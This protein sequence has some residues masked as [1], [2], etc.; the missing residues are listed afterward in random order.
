MEKIK[1]IVYGTSVPLNTNVLWL[2]P[3][4]NKLIAPYIFHNGNWVSINSWLRDYVDSEDYN[5]QRNAKNYTDEQVKKLSDSLKK[6]IDS[7]LTKKQDKLVSGTNI[8]T[9]NS[10]SVLGE[11][12]INIQ[13]N[14]QSN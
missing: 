12:N 5:I 11:G 10:E 2:K 14:S 7:E 4:S 8:K 1:E 3:Y 6:Y 9:I 13:N